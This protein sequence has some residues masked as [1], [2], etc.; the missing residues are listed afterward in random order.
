MNIIATSDTIANNI[1]K[2]FNLEPADGDGEPDI[3][4]YRTSHFTIKIHLST[5]EAPGRQHPPVILVRQRGKKL[6]AIRI[7]DLSHNPKLRYPVHVY[8]GSAEKKDP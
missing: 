2:V 5:Q 7:C 3:R 8:I 6:S 4:T 1:I